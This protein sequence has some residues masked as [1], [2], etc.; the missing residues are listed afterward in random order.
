MFDKRN[1]VVPIPATVSLLLTTYEKRSMLTKQ[2]A[3]C[4]RR[5]AKDYNAVIVDF[6]VLFKHLIKNQPKN[7][8]WIWDGIHPTPAGHAKM[9]E[10]WRKNVRLEEDKGR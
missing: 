7:G 1:I 2:L 6:D 3:E 10:L 5:I 4:T 8:Y 9:A